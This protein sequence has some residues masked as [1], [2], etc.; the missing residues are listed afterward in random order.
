MKKPTIPSRQQGVSLV[1][2]LVLV[3]LLSLL[4]LYG[5]GVLVLD[6]RSAANDYRAREA[7]TAGESGLDQGFSLLSI[8]R[9]RIS[10]AGF[11]INGDGSVSGAEPVWATCSSSASTPPCVAIRSDDRANWNFLTVNSAL[12]NA[13]AQGSFT[14]FLMTPSSGESTRLLYTIVASGAS[15]DGTSS[16][17]VKQAAYFYPLIF[18]TPAAPMMTYGEIGGSGNYNVVT[19]PDGAADGKALTTWS[20]GAVTLSGSSATC[21]VGEE[22]ISGATATGFLSTDSTYLYQTDSNGNSITMCAQCTCP[23]QK[24]LGRLSIAGDYGDDIVQN[25]P[26]FPPDVFKYLFGVDYTNYQQVRDNAT[27]VSDCSG[28]NTASSGLIW[29][30][31]SSCSITGSVGSFDKPVLLVVQDDSISVTGGGYIFGIVFAFASGG[32]S[33]TATDVHLAGGTTLYGA[34]MSNTRIDMGNGTYKMRFDK[35]VLANIQND[36][37]ARALSRVPGSW[38]DVQQ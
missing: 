21:H 9:S 17:I 19:N 33:S 13:P 27:V 35:N 15:A 34:V 29:V 8:N 6:T 2:T 37:S 20:R 16:A 25:D 22:T 14:L 1:V 7:L 28:L 38:S 31:G 30:E 11:D 10:A 3:V 18:G 5:A 36:P 24:D 26:S 32:Y 4:V 12:T 23:T